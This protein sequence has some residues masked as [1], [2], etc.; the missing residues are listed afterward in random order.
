MANVTVAVPRNRLVLALP[1]KAFS[2]LTRW[3]VIPLVILTTMVFT[4][5]FAPVLAPHDPVKASLVKRNIPPAWTAKGTSEHL[6]GTDPVGRDILSRL[7]FG[8]RVSLMVVGISLATG[9]LVGTTLGIIAGYF[10][11]LLDE[12]ISRFVD[13]WLSLPLIVL[14]LA[15]V[16]VFGQS[17]GV[18]I[19]LLALL[20]WAPFVRNVRAEV[21]VLKTKDYVALAKVAGASTLRIMVT[22]ILP[23]VLNTVIVI[24]TLRVGQLILFEAILSFLGAGIPPP[25][26]AWGVMVAD[27]RD[28]VHSAWWVSFFPGLAIFLVVMSLNFLGDW[29]RDRFDPRLRQL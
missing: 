3:P 24:A 27:G 4:A 20:A 9:L 22:H 11:G 2:A 21:M 29:M 8:A 10:G 5:I 1:G 19:G 14:A 28:Y 6:L 16:I 13:I 15:I 18:M 26:P 17:F 7:M 12:I 25:T 23:G